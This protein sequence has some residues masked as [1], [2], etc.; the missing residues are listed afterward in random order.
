MKGWEG[1]ES[2]QVLVAPTQAHRVRGLGG[3]FQELLLGSSLCLASFLKVLLQ[4]IGLLGPAR[5]GAAISST[6]DD[7]WKEETPPPSYPPGQEGPAC[8]P[9]MAP[10]QANKD[11]GDGGGGI[12]MKS[13]LLKQG[14][15]S[16]VV[17]TSTGKAGK[18]VRGV[19]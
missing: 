5:K 19:K 13:E 18:L 11:G 4:L 1:R 17:F 8:I 10:D 9:R 6:E 2:D 7:R 16:Q 3:D 15:H 14:Q 12:Y